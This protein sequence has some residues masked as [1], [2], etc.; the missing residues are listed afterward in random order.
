MGQQISK[1]VQV[2]RSGGLAP[3]TVLRTWGR[4]RGHAEDEG[5]GQDGQEEHL[6][7]KVLAGVV[8]N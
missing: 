8:A 2:T 4:G 7:D 3:S 6:E 1:T 5:R